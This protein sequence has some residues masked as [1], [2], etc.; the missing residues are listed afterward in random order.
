MTAAALRAAD[1]RHALAA[2]L[3]ADN[4]LTPQWRKAVEAVPR[5]AFLGEAMFRRLD[6]EGGPTWWEPLHRSDVKEE[7]WLG[8]AYTNATWVTQIDGVNAADATEP[9]TGTPTSSSSLPAVVVDML[10]VTGLVEGESVL[11]IGT[12]TGYSA[13]L[14]CQRLGGDAVT[15]IEVDPV[16]A[17]RARQTLTALGYEPTL[18]VG[19]GLCGYEQTFEYDRLIATCAARYIPAPWMRQVRDGGTIT[20]PL[21]GWMH[22]Y[23]L[24]HLTL[25]DDGTASGHFSQVDVSFMPARP[26]TAPPIT[27]YRLNR[28]DARESRIDPKILGD[29]TGRFVAQL[30]APSAQLIGAGDRVTLLD[31]AT[32]SQASTKPDPEGGWTVRQ[33]GPLRLW[34]GIEGA[35]VAWQEMSSPHQSAFGLTVTPDGQYVWL[36]TPDGPRWNLPA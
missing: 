8:L 12:G 20:V 31:V 15:S 11:E 7:E 17:E 6:D 21:W 35:V 14:M 9:L 24:A 18:V 34:D 13:A 26:Y 23:A 3:A 32:G 19:D 16:V 1:L 33:Y 36:G 10:E 4:H 27:H 28:G 25:A 22:G 5:E 30:G 29:W 2:Q